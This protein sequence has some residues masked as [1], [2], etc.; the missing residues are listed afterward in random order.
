MKPLR[1]ITGFILAGLMATLLGCASS[2]SS[3]DGL[4]GYWDDSITTS[5][6]KSA[7]YDDEK[8]KVSEI[9][10]ETVRGVVTLS[11]EVDSVVN[12]KRVELTARKVEG[13]KKVKNR[14]KVVKKKKVKPKPAA[15]AEQA[16]P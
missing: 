10:V 15:E 12:K 9:N 3:S 11:G 2:S 6:V 7:I 16:Q 1:L 14:I 13:V 4:G 8:L 5:K